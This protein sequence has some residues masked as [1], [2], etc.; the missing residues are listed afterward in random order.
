VQL[1]FGRI[2]YSRSECLKGNNASARKSCETSER[3]EEVELKVGK[4]ELE[5]EGV[6]LRRASKRR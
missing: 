3:S 6:K 2:L 4:R 1:G 5:G